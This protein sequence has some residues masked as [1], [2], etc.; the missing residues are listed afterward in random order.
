MEPTSQASGDGQEVN[1][2]AAV[3]DSMQASIEEAIRVAA[4]D[5]TRHIRHS[6]ADA[7]VDARRAAAESKLA[8]AAAEALA[9]VND[10]KKSANSAV[11][12]ARAKGAP[13]P[14]SQPL[15]PP[16]AEQVWSVLE[17]ANRDSKPPEQRTPKSAPARQPPRAAS[18]E[19]VDMPAA[20]VEASTARRSRKR[21]RSQA[22][23]EKPAEKGGNKHGKKH[24]KRSKKAKKD[25]SEAP[26]APAPEKPASSQGRPRHRGGQQAG[27]PN[28]HHDRNRSRSIQKG[29]RRRTSM[30]PANHAPTRGSRSRQRR[31]SP[32]GGRDAVKLRSS[33]RARKQAKRR[34]GYDRGGMYA[35]E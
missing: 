12:G 27:S 5:A 11:R 33:S 2:V 34:H 13:K 24:K 19:S 29:K 7:A 26:A 16:S 9:T 4:A 20:A 3:D 31:Q 32:S 30:S 17:Q 8:V 35:W 25:G 14:R 22:D 23:A 10:V 21:R 6:P 1:E 18:P 15:A 28:G